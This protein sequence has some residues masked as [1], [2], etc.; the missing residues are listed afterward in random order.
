[1]N[2]QFVLLATVHL[3]CVAARTTYEILKD[4]GLADPHNKI[5]FTVI[6]LAMCG[7]WATWFS[8]CPVDP[9]PLALPP[10]IRYAGFTIAVAGLIL[11]VVALIQLR[12]LENI[13]HL[14]TGGAFSRLRHP[15]YVG[16]LSWIIGWSTYHAAPISLA[17]GAITAANIFFWRALEEQ[18]LVHQFGQ[19]YQEYRARTWC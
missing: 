17:I 1:M 5:L 3:E 9:A 16:F 12:G 19:T 4:R 15:M 10:A 13:E 7:L 14:V 18:R 2:N 6:F 8:L 11:A